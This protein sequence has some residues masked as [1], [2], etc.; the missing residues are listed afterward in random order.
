M[1]WGIAIARRRIFGRM[2]AVASLEVEV[3]VE[4]EVEG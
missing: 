3:E 2:I 1:S 4:V